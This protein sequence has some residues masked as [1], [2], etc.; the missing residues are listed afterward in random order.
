MVLLSANSIC[1]SFG[2]NTILDNVNFSIN[3]DDRLGVVG[4]NGAGKT[5]LARIIAKEN[6][7]TSGNIFIAKNKTIGYLAQNAIIESNLNVFDEMLLAFPEAYAI[8]NRLEEIERKLNESK[9]DYLINE[10]SALTEKFSIIGGYEYKSRAKSTL[11]KFGF[12]ESFWKKNI[13]TLSGGERTRLALVKVLLSEPDLLILDEPTNHLDIST[14]EWL[15][16][17][18]SNYPKSMIVISHDRYFLDKVTNKTL[19]LSNTHAHLYNGNYSFYENQKFEDEKALQKKYDQQQKEISR[20]EAIIEQQR[21]WGQEHN[22]ITIKSKEKQ[23]EHMDLVSAPEKKAK[24][25]SMKF[26]KATT[27]ANDVLIVEKLGKKYGS[28]SIFSNMSF[29]LK[30]NDR[31]L[32]IGPN[33]SGKS[34]LM[35]IIG[36]IDDNYSGEFVL[37][38]NVLSAYFSQELDNLD[39]SN[40]II[41]EIIE[42]YPNLKNQ[43]IR[44]ALAKFL[45][46]PDDINKQID[47]LSGGEKAR[48]SFCK[49]MLSK[50]NFLIL[51]E[52]TNNLDIASKEILE[53][54]L[55]NLDGTILA[56]SHDRYF[57]NKLATRIIEIDNENVIVFNDNYSAFTDYK[58]KRQEKQSISSEVAKEKTSNK[59]DFENNKKL[60]SDIRKNENKIQRSEKEI[61]ELESLKEE[62]NQQI[63]DNSDN[64]QKLTE[65]YNKITEIDNRIEF[66]FNEI[67]DAEQMLAKCR[68]EGNDQQ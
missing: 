68:G 45:F 59:I 50:I 54:A 57:I 30:R 60:L 48:L 49:M 28:K 32:V 42:A 52:P 19:E 40:T 55:M 5:T 44:S 2:T 63:N 23:I 47:L 36:G 51:D 62:L 6:E 39:P 35:K 11:E 29:T 53:N 15:E 14:I 33:G 65:I 26:S 1:V 58:T 31:M 18:L 24:E 10:Y 41:G 37:G 12:D 20:I 46:G 13:S 67:E 64:Y 8:D 61:E 17:H 21:R 25:M 4:I 22:F 34:T 56:V 3:E 16:S 43:E 38:H 7:P 27:S 66:L 9:E